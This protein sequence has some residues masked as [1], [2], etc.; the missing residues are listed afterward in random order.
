LAKHCSPDRIAV[1]VTHNIAPSIPLVPSPFPVHVLSNSRPKG[2]GANHNQAFSWCREHFFCVI[3][4]DILLLQDPFD[5][6]ISALLEDDVGVVAPMLVDSSGK[7]QDSARKFPT[8]L[9]IMTRA[10]GRKYNSHEYRVHGKRI[11]PDWVAGMF[12]LFSADQYAAIGGFDE[13]YFMYC[14]DADICR[15]L[16][17][18]GKNTLLLTD[19]LAVHNPRRASH[20]R[21]SHLYWHL[22]SLTRFFLKYPFYTL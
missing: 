15:R 22:T 1:T 20:A 6:L 8:P 4:P 17:Q 3:N 13:R 21:L 5:R 10:I 9:R 19:V 16:A 11:M 7:V 2:F 18:K 14:E 12:M